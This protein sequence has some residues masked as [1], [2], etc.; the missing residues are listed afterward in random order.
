M[1][2]IL[3]YTLITILFSS[4]DDFLDV[5]PKGKLLPQTMQDYDEMM[6]DPAHSSAIYP[7]VDMCGDNITLE[8]TKIHFNN[9][10]GKAYLWM[11]E[12]YTATEDDA[13][14]N[15][16]YEHI[17]TFNLVAERVDNATEGNETDRL[18]IKGEAFFNRAYYYWFLHSCYAKA[19][20]PATAATDLSVPLRTD[21]DLEAK[22]SRATSAEVVKQL[23]A[24]I[25]HPEY[26]PEKA[27][28]EYRISRGGAY[29]L[30]A[31]IYLSLGDYDN[32]QKHA[33]RALEQNNTLLDY[34]T[35][36][37]K[38]PAK[39]STGIE[40]R[41]SNYRKS[42]EC[43]MYRGN[44]FSD[45]LVNNSQIS[46]DLLA[47]YDT[48]TDLRYKFNFTRIE[49]NG[50]PRKE[51][52]ATY[53]QLL[54][55]NISV[56]EMMLIQAECMARKGDRECLKVLDKLRENRIA[57]ASWQP[58][59]V[60]DSKLLETVLEERQRE[61]PFHGMRFFDM[62]RLA[63]EGIYTKTVTRIYKGQFFTLAP[64]SNQYLFP[65]ASKVQSMN[66]KIE[67]NPR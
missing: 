39:P 21:S 29:A 57:R 9:S 19:Y 65:I 3:L 10:D 35:Y 32:A 14:W 24:D 8:E 51:K 16:A 62:K 17:Y 36:S 7:L 48:L 28:T 20:N 50:E 66:N 52:N 34:N 27:A 6:A 54:D 5:T 47:V 18:R 30:A 53:M 41:P 49:R 44:N 13:V 40:N 63:K 46:D 42:P 25:I 43:L 67:S 38:N 45:I 61:L 59:N 12:Y 60:P 31:R 64:N 11:D 55:Y 4:C 26:L 23:L 2:K 15:N 56:P 37:F 1:K 33:E 58:L 22:L